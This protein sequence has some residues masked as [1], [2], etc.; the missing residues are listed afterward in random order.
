MNSNNILAIISCAF[1]AAMVSIANSAAQFVAMAI[2]IFVPVAVSYALIRIGKNL[3]LLPKN[4]SVKNT[5]AANGINVVKNAA[6]SRNVR[7][8]V[9]KTISEQ[10]GAHLMAIP[11]YA[12]KA[13]GIA[14]P[15][16]KEIMA[17]GL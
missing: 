13:Q 1:I 11:A 3:S 14:Y 4:I 9:T 16:T 8:V 10:K 2:I 12:R 5:T 17:N 7:N 15:I 6:V